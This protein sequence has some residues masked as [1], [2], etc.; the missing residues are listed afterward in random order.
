VDAREDGMT[1]AFLGGL[2]DALRFIVT[3]SEGPGGA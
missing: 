3:K 1:L 2:G